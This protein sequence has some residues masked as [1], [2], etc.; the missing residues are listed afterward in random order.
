M[1]NN[2]NTVDKIVLFIPR[3]VIEAND[4][5]FVLNIFDEVFRNPAL[6]PKFKNQVTIGFDGYDND[7]KEV[8]EITAVRNYIQQLTTKFPYWLYFLSLDDHSLQIMMLILCKFEKVHDGWKVKLY[9]EDF[10][11]VLTYL[12]VNL[13]QLYD[14]FSLPRGEIIPLISKVADYLEKYGLWMR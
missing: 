11:K 6:I 2:L 12:H 10:D 5:S 1:E 4:H 14:K 3:N 9:E 7:P 13:T 8:F